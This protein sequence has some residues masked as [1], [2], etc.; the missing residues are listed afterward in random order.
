MQKIAVIGAGITGITTAYALLQRGFEVTVFDRNRYA[1]M[2]TSYANGGQLSASNAETWNRWATVFKG[3]KWMFEP[4]APLLVNPKPSWHKYS[5]MAEFMGNIPGYKQNTIETVKLAIIAREHLKHHAEK[6]GFDFHCEDRGILHVYEDEKE[7]VHA[8]K[9][10]E[11]LAEGGLKREEVSSADIEKLE[12]ALKR[13]FIGGFYTESDF[14][15]DIH[16]YTRGL[17]KACDGK[18]VDFHYGC[19]VRTLKHV[20]NGIEVNWKDEDENRTTETFD[21]IVVC[22]GV[23]SRDLAAP[24]WVTG[25][26]SIRSKVIRLR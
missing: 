14:T 9:V 24:N 25:L 11:L 15:G 23:R 16:T 26:T 4:G 8:A 21:G 10:N 6:E 1:A 17:S 22:A 19:K 20:G 3:I 7:F 5:W 18:G 12:P 2:E 13:K